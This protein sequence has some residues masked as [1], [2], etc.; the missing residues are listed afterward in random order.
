MLICN[1]MPHYLLP[2]ICGLKAFPVLGLETVLFGIPGMKAPGL[3][4]QGY[5]KQRASGK[6]ELINSQPIDFI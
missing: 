4:V 3:S 1:A 5:G 6:R 2:S